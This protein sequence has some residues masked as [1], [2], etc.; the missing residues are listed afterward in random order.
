MVSEIK[1]ATTA[2]ADAMHGQSDVASE[3]LR[4]TDASDLNMFGDLG[5][6]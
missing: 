6:F 5:R 3:N 2:I 1:N 4:L